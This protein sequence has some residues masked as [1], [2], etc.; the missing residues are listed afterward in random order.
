M[1]I[2]EKKSYLLAIMLRYTQSSRSE[3][4]AILDEFCAVCNYNRKYAI[5]I[6]GKKPVEPKPKRGPKPLYQDS[7]FL[8]SL[9]TIWFAA[10]QPCSRKLKA[11][12]PLWLPSYEVT[13]GQLSTQ[14]R[15]RLLAI[16]RATIDRV[17]KPVRAV[18]KMKGRSLTKPG[19][20]LKSQIEIQF[21]H[22]GI[23]K[24]G[25]L[26]ADTV[27]HCGD[28]IGGQFAWSLTATDICT[29]WTENRALWNKNSGAVYQEMSGIESI[30]PFKILGFDSDNGAEFMNHALHDY[31]TKRENPVSFTR[32][33]PYHKNDNAHV[34]QKNWT[35]VR[36]LFGY[37]RLDDRRV[38]ALM[39]DL[40]RHEWSLYQ[41][42]F[43]PT[44]K[45]LHKQRIGSKY[46]KTYES[47]KTPYERVLASDYVEDSVKERLKDT[48]M[49]L[50]P[51]TLKNEIERKLE[52]IFKHV[53][54]TSNVRLRI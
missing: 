16:S 25:F 38:V 42:H 54:V 50:N 34:E 11:I 17:L 9:K 13:Y 23:K 4:R 36:Q 27:A 40:Y 24:P 43:M 15:Q 21:S 37:D 7:L 6:L 52:G 46:R 5:R 2:S 20:L 44:M 30:L 35:H 47:P 51:F 48:H 22:W 14:I 39:N 12:I 28:N 1:G 41:N 3:K 33:R 26:E 53:K 45:L 18:N 8:E 10:D 32:S 19:S 29:G 31:F 49:T